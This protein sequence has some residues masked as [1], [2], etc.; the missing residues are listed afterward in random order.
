MEPSGALQEVANLAE[1]FDR[2]V[3][4]RDI[5]EGDMRR[6]FGELSSLG[7][8]HAEH[9]TAHLRQHEDDQADQNQRR[10]H[11]QCELAPEVR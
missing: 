8:T 5:V 11:A 9:A 10:S 2:F 3:R 7:F 1:F 6:I 4:A